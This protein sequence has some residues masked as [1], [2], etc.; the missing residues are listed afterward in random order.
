MTAHASHASLGETWAIVPVKRFDRAKT[1]L[2]DT[3]SPADRTALAKAMLGDVLDQLART[4]GIDGV[5]VVTCDAEAGVIASSFGANVLAD[6]V[7]TGVNDAVLLGIRKLD[8][9]GKSGV[10]V[11]PG[12]LP[13]LTAG[14]LR[15]IV[16]AL[17]HTP[18]V[19]APAARDGGTNILALSPPGVMAPA[20][21]RD[22]LA[23]HVAAAKAIGLRPAILTLEGASHD[24]DVAADLVFDAGLR[25]GS[26]TRAFLR[27]FEVAASPV[28]A[29]LYAKASPR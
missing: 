4:E 16:A 23:R 9:P 6:P 26:R 27:R 21:G 11:V 17:T 19:L 3:L 10:V 2:A 1:R 14:E 28:P 12:D 24:I 5:L 8:V 13:F 18:V 22:S 7:E 29:E 15:V 25:V 20:F